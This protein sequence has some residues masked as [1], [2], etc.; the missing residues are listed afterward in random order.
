[1]LFDFLQLSFVA[2]F[3]FTLGACGSGSSEGSGSGSG[4]GSA[5]EI[6]FL[7]ANDSVHGE[8]LWKTDG[9][10]VGT[11]LLKDICPGLCD[12]LRYF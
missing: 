3:P 11:Q 7:A 12:G 10:V 2:V 1:M 8:E 5:A 9:T 6:M 4:S